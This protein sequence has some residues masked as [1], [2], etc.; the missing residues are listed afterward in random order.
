[1]I[2]WSKIEGS[3]RLPSAT[4]IEEEKSFNFTLYS[5]HATGLTLLLSVAAVPPDLRKRVQHVGPKLALAVLSVMTPEEMA[6][7]TRRH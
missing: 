2:I 4:W 6:A 5:K 7:A 3:P 1:M